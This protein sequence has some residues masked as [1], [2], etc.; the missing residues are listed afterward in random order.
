LQ[1]INQ[2]LD[3]NKNL[4]ENTDQE[5]QQNQND[6]NEKND[7]SKLNLITLKY[8]SVCQCCK[9]NFDTSEHLPFLLLCEHFFCK[10]CIESYFTDENGVISCPE[11][12][13]VANNISELKILKNLI[14]GE[15]RERNNVE[16]N[17]SDDEIA[18][19]DQDNFCSQHKDQKFSHYIENTNEIIC[20]YCAFN[21]FKSSPNLQIKELSEK[22]N[23]II[24]FVEKI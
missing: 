1:E 10:N 17:V 4:E 3:E 16:H 23:E 14:I 5:Y 15:N 9:N 19:K 24:R 7:K 12:G 18:N 11:D 13:Q 2:N 21:R 6:N 8:I 20:V 22:S